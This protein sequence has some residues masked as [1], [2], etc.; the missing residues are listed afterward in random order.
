VG[1]FWIEY[2]RVDEA[3]HF[4]GLRLN[5]WTSIVVFVLA[6]VYMVVSARR[7]PGREEVVE[8]GV[9]DGDGVSDGEADEA[10]DSVKLDKKSEDVKE[11]AESGSG[12]SESEESSDSADEKDEAESAKKS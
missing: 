3:H 10:D 8:P 1:R 4:L 2:M 5:G 7:R 12:S 9:P 6:V 11:G